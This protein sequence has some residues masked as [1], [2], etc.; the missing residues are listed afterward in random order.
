MLQLDTYQKLTKVAVTYVV[1]VD[2][3]VSATVAG[4]RY[5]M[6]RIDVILYLFLSLLVLVCDP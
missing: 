1:C 6:M 4:R 3:L 5:Q 2:V